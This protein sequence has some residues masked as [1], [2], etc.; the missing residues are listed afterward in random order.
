MAL[1]RDVDAWR[2]MDWTAG[3][4]HVTPLIGSLLDPPAWRDAPPLRAVGAVLHLGALVRHSRR[5]AAEV[6]RVNVD[7]TLAMVRAAAHWGCRLVFVSTSGAVGCFR[8]PGG[9]ADEDAP[10]CEREVRRWPYY[11][12]KLVAER[13]A[14]RLAGELAVELVVVRPPVVLG[15]GDHRF[16]T[17]AN[18][19]R[20][21]QGRLPFLVHGGIHYADVR[22]AAGA[23]LHAALR[24]RVRPVYHCTGTMSTIEE[25]FGLAERVSGVP[26][27]RRIVPY[28]LAWGLAMALAP[29]HVL[30]DPVVIELASRFWTTTS[31]YAESDLGY[32]RRDPAETMADTIAWLRRHHPDLRTQSGSQRG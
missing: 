8:R 31:R 21:L 15:P 10:F 6:Y 11:H 3:L 12:S 9:G 30:P 13:E 14:R 2:A 23:L 24:D 32:R 26:A 25:F 4:R 1:V 28:P 7:G 22:D 19:L 27:P 17:T 16:R 29:F 20:Y 5:G 18:L